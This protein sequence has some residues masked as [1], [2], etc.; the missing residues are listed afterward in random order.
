MYL[1]LLELCI[2]LKKFFA[3]V[4]LCVF[5]CKLT[6]IIVI[7]Y[8]NISICMTKLHRFKKKLHRYKQKL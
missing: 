3:I 2:F 6:I 8:K 1:C 5:I 4:R 7:K